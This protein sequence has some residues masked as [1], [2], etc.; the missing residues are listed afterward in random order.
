[1]K[2][3]EAGPGLLSL[4]YLTTLAKRIRHIITLRDTLT[5]LHADG[6]AQAFWGLLEDNGRDL[7]RS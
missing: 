2:F 4:W 6:L 5:F 1:M 3:G 7:C